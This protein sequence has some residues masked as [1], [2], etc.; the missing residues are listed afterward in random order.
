M[1]NQALTCFGGKT[2]KQPKNQSAQPV[3]S[4]TGIPSP[5]SPVK[6]I[7]NQSQSKTKA[8]NLDAC[9]QE[10]ECR[11]PSFTDLV[12]KTL[13]GVEKLKRSAS[14][15][16]KSSKNS[17][18]NLKG[19]TASL[20]HNN[21]NNEN[22]PEIFDKNDQT[23]EESS[24]AK[25]NQPDQAE[26]EINELAKTYV[27]DIMQQALGSFQGTFGLVEEPNDETNQAAAPST[28]GLETLDELGNPPS[29]LS[30]TKTPKFICPARKGSFANSRKSSFA[31]EST[32]GT[33]NHSI[34]TTGPADINAVVDQAIIE[35][36]EK[37]KSTSKMSENSN[38]HSGSNLPDK[39]EPLN[40][41]NNE[42]NEAN[43]SVQKC[44]RGS[45]DSLLR[46][47]DVRLLEK[48]IAMQEDDGH[49][50][51]EG[52]SHSE[53]QLERIRRASSQDYV[54]GTMDREADSDVTIEEGNVEVAVAES[55]STVKGENSLDNNFSYMIEI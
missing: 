33:D 7:I 46:I 8:V 28:E 29:A 32:D 13:S 50:L 35:A 6:E 45:V 55:K 24:L 18:K 39:V 36:S 26:I 49:K 34:S 54:I 1:G 52:N 30:S 16:S 22:S 51:P 53:E 25:D 44:R 9:D 23:R 15:I 40:L 11:K 5:T 17:F 12:T 38:T 3:S 21:V 4:K 47:I 20:V 27:E 42:I 2:K 43:H 31:V 14:I 19:S 48:T 37:I 41:S 10:K